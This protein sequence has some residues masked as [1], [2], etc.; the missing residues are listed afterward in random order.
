MQVKLTEKEIIKCRFYRKR[1]YDKNKTS[2]SQEYY[3]N[4]TIIL[5]EY[6]KNMSQKILQEYYKNI[7]RI[8]HATFLSYF[9]DLT[10]TSI[11]P[12]TDSSIGIVTVLLRG[13]ECVR[14]PSAAAEKHVTL[15][16]TVLGDSYHQKTIVKL[17][18]E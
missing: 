4:T 15:Y 2:F 11:V 5:Q 6:Y 3:K 18:N 14:A 12:Q 7:T 8:L 10:Y 17:T 13:L 9:W 1:E 16:F